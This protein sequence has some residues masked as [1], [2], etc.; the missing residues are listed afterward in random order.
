MHRI[1]DPLLTA[2]DHLGS[3]GQTAWAIL[4]LMVFPLCAVAGALWVWGTARGHDSVQKLPA[5]CLTLGMTAAALPLLAMLA[6]ALQETDARAAFFSAL[7][8]L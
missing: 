2:A 4:V 3:T 8:S 1:A 6:W 5:L 7:S